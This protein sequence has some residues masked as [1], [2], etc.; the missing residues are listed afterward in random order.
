MS[1]RNLILCG[2]G[3]KV[4]STVGCLRVLQKKKLLSSIKEFIGCSGGN[5]ANL[6]LILGADIYESYTF[7]LSLYQN[8]FKDENTI[9]NLINHCGLIQANHMRNSLEDIIEKY[10][11]IRNIT[12]EQLSKKYKKDMTCVVTNI[13][14]MKANY[15]NNQYCP[16]FIVSDAIMASCSLPVIFSPCVFLKVYLST[17]SN[18]S[19][20]FKKNIF[21]LSKTSTFFI[22]VIKNKVIITKCRHQLQ[23]VDF[24]IYYLK[25]WIIVSVSKNPR[26]TLNHKK[27][28]SR[29]S[30]LSIGDQLFF[31]QKYYLSV[32]DQKVYADGGIIDNYP[33]HLSKKLSGKTIGV[34]FELQQKIINPDNTNILFYLRN[35][36]NGI[37]DEL[38]YTKI[39]GLKKDSICIKLP[40]YIKSTDMN[41]DLNNIKK[42]IR[43]GAETTLRF[44]KKQKKK[45]KK[46]KENS[47]N[48]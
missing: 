9:I 12:F 11:G 42:I 25:K 43:I 27:I 28:Y 34:Y 17:T 18:N 48:I 6:I 30:I 4:F 10:S 38:Q 40:N 23:K 19:K 41:P 44:L 24:L 37:C 31:N 16:N 47:V 22:G 45:I 7:S 21:Y 36:I 20:H 14:T 15:L 5:I 2:G 32:L 33:I 1:Y 39:K 26:D 13:N 35:I 29:S 46:K 8:F 3:S